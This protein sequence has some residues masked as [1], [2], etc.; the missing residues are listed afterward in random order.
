MPFLLKEELI[1]IL[2][3]GDKIEKGTKSY[4]KIKEFL[5]GIKFTLSY[6]KVFIFHQ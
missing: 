1:K 4:A 6:V 3:K 5:G 2:F